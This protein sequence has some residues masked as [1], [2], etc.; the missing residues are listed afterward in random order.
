MQGS[1]VRW[2]CL[3][4]C[5]VGAGGTAAAAEFATAIQPLLA[6]YCQRCHGADEQNAQVR[7]DRIGGFAAADM[8]LWTLVHENLSRGEM[9]PPDEPQPT[10]AEKRLLQ[11]WILA[12]ARSH[13][14]DSGGRQRRLNRR[15]FSAALQDLIGVPIDFA[16][17][18]PEDGRTAGFD[19]GWQGLQDAAE[20]VSQ[21][22]A[23]AERAAD[24]IRLMEPAG[25]RV[26]QADFREQEF[27]DFRRFVEGA[28]GS[29]GISSKAKGMQCRRGIGLFL[30]ATWAGPGQPESFLRLPARRGEETVLKITLRVAARR[31]MPGIPQ[32][33]LW[34]SVGGRDVDY[35]TIGDAP[36]TLTYA[37]RTEDLQVE[38][39][40]IKIRLRSVVEVP[41]AVAGFEND[42]PGKPGD[43]PP[44]GGKLLRPRFDQA[45]LRNPDEQPVPSIV[46]E[47]LEIDRDHRAA[48][49]PAAWRSDLGGMVDD[50]ATARRA[51]RGWLER[52]WRRPA[53]DAEQQRF[54]VLYEQLRARG[55]SFD[56]AVRTVFQAVLMGGPFRYLASPAD[57]D[58]VVAQ[59]AIASRLSFML[60]GAP[61]DRELR[62]LAAAGKLRDPAVLDGQV[63]R[64][65]ADAR[66]AAFFRPF[67]T[68]WL[69]LEQP[70]TLV[71]A[72]LQDRDS[73]FHRHLRSSLKEETIQYVSRLFA[74]NRPAGEIVDSDWTM[75]NDILAV[76]YG[77]PS[78]EGATLRKV[79][80]E[81]R[82]DDPRGGGVLAHGGIQSM[83]CW[84]GDNWLIYRGAWALDR[85]LDDPPPPAPLDVP[86]LQPFEGGNRGKSF[87]ELLVQH[88]ADKN[89]AVCHRTIDPLGFAFQNFDLSGR[90]RNVEHERYSRK[91]LEGRIEWNGVGQSRPVDAAGRL[92]R[93]EEFQGFLECKRL[94]ARHYAADMVRGLMKKLTLYGTGRQA[95]LIDLVE[96]RRIMDDHAAQ[97]YPLRD[98]LKALVRSAVFLDR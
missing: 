76:H 59:H 77:Y 98:L 37:F 4:V 46:L 78:M 30:P 35:R 79:V 39:D 91:E 67:V 42:W 48:W 11:E 83:L 57:A 7:F 26:I 43:R 97:G 88:Q 45:A 8:Q 73:M 19:T 94:I 69:A 18:L 44:D 82:E 2:V 55:L 6:R 71:M 65:L 41:Y 75:M 81:S 31:P 32:P 84:M 96:I 49:P 72:S 85:I 15:E 38:G 50:D 21:V 68:Q 80:L 3:A 16:V 5:L 56:D 10:A 34:V 27:P 22:L 12:Q 13:A 24:S 86:D 52:A 63:D 62:E 60:V 47:T 23:A 9:P 29:E 74:D 58:P 70:I 93:G 33:T 95:D 40:D 51:I 28:W 89:C 92:P 66:S 87:R 61:P 54:V 25:Q 20:S 1:V 36:Q 64:L 17:G 53:T 14:G 90:W